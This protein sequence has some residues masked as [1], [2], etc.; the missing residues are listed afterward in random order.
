MNAT[1]SHQI[2]NTDLTSAD[3]IIRF[4]KTPVIKPESVTQHTF[5]VTLFTRLIASH[6]TKDIDNLFTLMC[7]DAALTHDFVDENITGDVLF[8]FK[9]NELNG[10]KVVELVNEFVESKMDEYYPTPSL[11]NNYVRNSIGLTNQ[12]II[13]SI[14]KVADWLACMKYEEQELCLGN[15][16]FIPILIKSLKKYDKAVVTLKMEARNYFRRGVNEEFFVELENVT[17]ECFTIK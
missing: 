13:K 8:D 12:K 6:L 14:I 3:Y 5:W 9:H 10:D 17:Y 4:N 1:L 16:A 15:K 7:I 11:F 2:F